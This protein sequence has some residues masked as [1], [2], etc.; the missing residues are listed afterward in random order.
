MLLAA[1][2]VEVL[3]VKYVRT[4]LDLSGDRN[5]EHALYASA[6]WLASPFNEMYVPWLTATEPV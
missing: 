3:V 2:A 1:A 6:F 4:A 5:W